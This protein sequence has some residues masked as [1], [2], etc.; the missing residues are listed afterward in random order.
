MHTT[1]R[2]NILGGVQ[3]IIWIRSTP[4]YLDKERHE[5][6]LGPFSWAQRNMAQ[7]T[8]PL[9]LASVRTIRMQ[10]DASVGLQA[11]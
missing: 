8:P 4:A 9:F 5:P 1:A 2:Q 6:Y 3:M 7:A 11:G 10:A